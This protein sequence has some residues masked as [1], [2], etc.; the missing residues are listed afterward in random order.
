MFG[1]F[2]NIEITTEQE[3]MLYMGALAQAD[4]HMWGGKNHTQS[5]T[6]PAVE[7]ILG[8]WAKF[9]LIAKIEHENKINYFFQKMI[10]EENSYALINNF[11][12][13]LCKTGVQVHGMFLG[14]IAAIDNS[15]IPNDF[16][17]YYGKTLI[18]TKNNES[19]WLFIP[20]QQ[21]K[22]RV[23]T[24]PGLYETASEL[25]YIEN[26]MISTPENFVNTVKTLKQEFTVTPP[27]RRLNA[28]K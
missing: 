3:I 26:G 28:F 25:Y 1:Y 17:F 18:T 22:E 16:F 14:R 10:H 13:E 6:L 12:N 20:S 21:E 4:E 9:E 11:I 8:E 5:K 23:L 15:K 27:V 7:S 19:E 2:L 24:K